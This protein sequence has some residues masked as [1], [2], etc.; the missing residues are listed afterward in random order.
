MVTMG[1]PVKGLLW[2]HREEVLGVAAVLHNSEQR[3]RVRMKQAKS[4][5]ERGQLCS[6]RAKNPGSEL[7]LSY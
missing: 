2:W 5:Q 1:K 6:L 3:R 7:R 4:G